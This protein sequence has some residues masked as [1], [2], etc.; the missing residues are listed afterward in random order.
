MQHSFF[1]NELLFWCS[2]QLIIL[3]IC[4]WMDNTPRASFPSLGYLMTL[5][6]LMVLVPVPLPPYTSTLLCSPS[7]MFPLLFSFLPVLPWL[8]NSTLFMSI[9][10]LILILWLLVQCQHLTPGKWWYEVTIL[11]EWSLENSDL[12]SGRQGRRSRQLVS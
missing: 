12:N 6:A 4:T 11:W 10:L 8:P 7:C 1:C 9:T 5:S 3:Y 2:V